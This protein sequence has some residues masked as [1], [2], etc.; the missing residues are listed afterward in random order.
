MPVSDDIILGQVRDFY[1]NSRDY[2]GIPASRLADNQGTSWPDL[3]P[4]L[5]RLVSEG[6]LDLTF[7]SHSDNPHIKRIATL[8]IA[9]QVRRLEAEN[10]SGICVYPSRETIAASINE[11][12][13]DP[14]PYTKRLLLGEPQL[15][16]V[17]F[18]LGVLERYFRDPR[19]LFVFTD[20]AG[21]ISIAGPHFESGT[22][23]DR[24][25]VFLQSFGIA[26][27][28][29][30]D[31]VVAVFLRY[32]ANLTPEHQQMWRTHEI[33][34]ACRMNGDYERASIWGQWPKFHSVYQAFIR[35]QVEINRICQL[36]WKK[37]LFKRTFDDDR[38]KGF[39]P[40]LRP[41]KR[42]LEEFASLLDKM[43][44][45]N[46]SKDFFTGDIPLEDKIVAAD[47]SIERRP[48][49]TLTL[50][51]RWLKKHYRTANGAD[52]SE[53]VMPP[54]REIREFRQAPAHELQ[55]DEYDLSFPKKQD[56]LLGGVTIALTKLRLALMSHP[57]AKG[58]APPAW[59]GGEDIVFY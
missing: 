2:N 36:I 40:M 8:P 55:E 27:N 19:Y 4:Q 21:R 47:K 56:E 28:E 58:Y 54:F 24:D 44:S 18:E 43:L 37:E 23:A 49:G 53:E 3:R 29:R 42:N 22:V 38:P 34:E 14:K 11:R 13:Y 16:P 1:L 39:S 59:L 51:E 57:K 41:T 9:D 46:I 50:L 31:R 25:Q 26:Y 33:T 10:P 35:E 20:F 52:V 6:K 32:L 48:I 17:F 12:E 45:E 15:P 5:A 30:K 7:A